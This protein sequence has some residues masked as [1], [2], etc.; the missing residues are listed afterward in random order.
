M[1]GTFV[2]IICVSQ[3][4]LIKF[5]QVRYDLLRDAKYVMHD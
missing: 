2:E 3:Y 1:K 4:E 5:I